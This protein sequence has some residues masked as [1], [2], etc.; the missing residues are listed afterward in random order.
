MGC[1]HPRWASLSEDWT[2]F[3]VMIQA[4][5]LH[6]GGAHDFDIVYLGRFGTADELSFIGQGGRV[7]SLAVSFHLIWSSRS[8]CSFTL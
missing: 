6:F 3:W 4:K 7:D 2:R 1:V 8:I 5:N